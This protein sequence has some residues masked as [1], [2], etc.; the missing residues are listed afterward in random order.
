MTMK[1]IIYALA[2]LF[3]LGGL[4]SCTDDFDKT[5]TNPNVV[6]E[7][8]PDYVFSGIVYKSMN[9]YARANHRL[10]HMLSNY[11]ANWNEQKDTEDMSSH[12][13]DFYVKSLVDLEKLEESFVNTE[14]PGNLGY[15]LMTWKAYMYYIMASSWGGLPMSDVNPMDLRT[16]YKYDKQED[17]Y[18]NILDLLDKAVAGFDTNGDKLTH[19]PLLR[20]SDGKS[21]IDKW[22]KFA[23]SLRLNIALTIQNMDAQLAEQH[24]RKALTGGNENYLIS[25]VGDIIKFKWGS[26]VNADASFYYTN[27]LMGM[28]QGTTSGWYTYPAM[29]HNFFLYMK[30][31]NDPRL[32]KFVVRA[33]G[34][35]MSIMNNDTITRVNPVNPNLRDSL[36]VQYGLPYL[37]RREGKI[38]APTGWIVET[39]PNSPTG[40]AYR[41]PYDDISNTN[42]N[43]CFVS[44]DYIK[45]DAEAVLISWAEVCFMKA[46]VAIKYPGIISG[47]AQQYYE[48]GI[49]ASMKQYGVSDTEIEAYMVQPGVVW[50]TDGNGVWE[51]RRFY[52]ADIKGKGGDSNHLEQIYKQ[53]YIADFFYGHAGWTLERRTRAMKF[54][55]HFYNNPSTEGSNGVCDYMQERLLYPVNEQ[56]YNASGY[57]QAV[58][59]LQ[60][61]SPAPN[62]S[63]H[64][65]N[66]FTLLKFAAPQIDSGDLTR[67]L[68]G[69]IVYD[70]GF[71]RNWYGKTL[72]EVL[73]ITGAANEQELESKILYKVA[74]VRSTYDPNTGQRYVWDEDSQSYIIPPATKNNN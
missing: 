49:R 70:G 27:F 71:I 60:S 41:S 34:S 3:T 36:I 46:E 42:K 20:G 73:A 23:N 44:R 43:E 28:D 17:M 72:E 35:E 4:Y 55:P 64:G 69:R 62:P 24:I 1:K 52:K 21:D 40:E 6:Y 16:S 39:N 54:P 10:Y 74:D 18:K 37:P 65:D 66:F 19:D 45:A 50:N 48:D 33:E 14:N 59:D 9:A 58:I 67:W 15:I 31:Y 2:V 63:R 29:S 56:S 12:F 47:T 5:N 61:E 13:E 51:Y 53:W 38:G 25:S 11:V 8:H 57:A 32:P 7:T 30:S 26:D 68:S 22:R